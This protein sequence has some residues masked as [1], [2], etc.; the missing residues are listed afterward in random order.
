M[1][2]A[3]FLLSYDKGSTDKF[4]HAILTHLFCPHCVGKSST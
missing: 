2:P 4:S 1:C 3:L